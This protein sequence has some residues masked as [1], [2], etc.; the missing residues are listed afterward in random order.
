[1]TSSQDP[2]WTEIDHAKNLE[3]LMELFPKIQSSKRPQKYALE[4]LRQAASS[5]NIERYNLSAP[6]VFSHP[7][8]FNTTYLIGEDALCPA[9][10]A[11]HGHIALDL[12]ERCIRFIR[13]TD[14]GYL[15][16]AATRAAIEVN[17]IDVIK[18]ALQAD[19][20][21]VDLIRALELACKTAKVHLVAAIVRRIKASL[22]KQYPWRE[23]VLRHKRL[24][25]NLADMLYSNTSVDYEC[26]VLPLLPLFARC[27]PY[28]TREIEEASG[29][30]FSRDIHGDRDEQRR[31]DQGAYAC[32]GAYEDLTFVF[33]QDELMRAIHE[34]SR[35]DEARF[36]S[37]P[38]KIKFATYS[39]EDCRIVL[40]SLELPDIVKTELSEYL[41]QCDVEKA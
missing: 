38:R 30:P 15:A 4:I 29:N 10:R 24:L 33:P 28:H 16:S 31:L 6:E 34:S 25:P 1:M 11:G 9:I 8:S 36:R 19:F 23:T 37:V 18:R 20:D 2:L 12:L 14:L 21:G 35:F 3:A 40:D 5:G 26:V 17:N 27:A 41:R 7:I 13:P 39:K 22:S 32:L